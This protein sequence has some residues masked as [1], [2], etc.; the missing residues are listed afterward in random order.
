MFGNSLTTVCGLS[1]FYFSHRPGKAILQLT[2]LENNL[3]DFVPKIWTQPSVL[4]L[5]GSPGAQ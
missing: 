5:L 2:L 3:L 4:W 1:S